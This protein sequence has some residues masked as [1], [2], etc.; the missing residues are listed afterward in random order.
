[1]FACTYAC[2]YMYVSIRMHARE[3]GGFSQSQSHMYVRLHVRTY[4]YVIC[5]PMLSLV[6]PFTV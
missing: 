4:A 3:H 5:L 1:M 6:F 2:M